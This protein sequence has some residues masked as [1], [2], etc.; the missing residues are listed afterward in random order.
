MCTEWVSVDRRFR[1]VQEKPLKKIK[2]DTWPSRVLLQR[3]FNLWGCT[4]PCRT[5]FANP[6]DLQVQFNKLSCVFKIPTRKCN[7]AI[8]RTYGSGLVNVTVTTYRKKY[9]YNTSTRG[10]ISCY[11]CRLVSSDAYDFVVGRAAI[12][13][14]ENRIGN[15]YIHTAR[16]WLFVYSFYVVESS[17]QKQRFRFRFFL[18]TTTRRECR[19]RTIDE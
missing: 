19:T 17:I 4:F 3:T 2:I 15:V 9:G 7:S 12:P 16:Y 5:S 8:K 6:C 11:L 13:N 14:Y 18:D 1:Q 10:K